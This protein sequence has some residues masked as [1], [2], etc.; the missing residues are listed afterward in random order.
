MLD[1]IPA[2]AASPVG[3]DM[4]NMMARIQRRPICP[5]GWGVFGRKQEVAGSGNDLHALAWRVAR[6]PL[7]QLLLDKDRLAAQRPYLLG[8]VAQPGANRSHCNK[9]W[10]CLGYAAKALWRGEITLCHG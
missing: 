6:A 4:V 9:A 7:R 3:T 1:A 5:S 2:G 8:G 10:R